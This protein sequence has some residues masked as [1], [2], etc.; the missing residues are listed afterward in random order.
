M[1]Y[2]LDTLVDITR[3]MDPDGK[4]AKIA[5]VLAE[6]NDMVL[7]MPWFPSNQ[8][9]TQVSTLQTGEPEGQF[10]ALNEAV[11]A[12]KPETEQISDGC[13]MLEAWSNIDC[14]AA[15]M[16]GNVS[17]YLENKDKAFIRGLGKTMAKTV[18][19]GDI[20]TN[21]KAFNGLAVRYNSTST[22]RGKGQI[23]KAGGSGSVNTSIY[24][25]KWGED[26]CHGLYPKDLQ[27]GLRYDFKGK[28]TVSPSAG[29]FM[30]VYQGKYEWFCGLHVVDYQAVVRIAN[31]D[32]T[33][34]ATAGTGSDT[35]ANLIRLMSLALDGLRDTNGNVCFYCNKTVMSIL[36]IQMM[37]RSNTW[38]T[39]IE[40][41]ADDPFN[42]VA[43]SP[44]KVSRCA[45]ST[46]FSTL[47][48]LFRSRLSP[49]KNKGG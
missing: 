22:G 23:L 37:N 7:D 30:D 29:T 45:A 6:T 3:Q 5:D 33:A 24:L 28:V 8:T 11:G 16:T 14:V 21:K 32:T 1:A 44:S 35:A 34:L 48:R 49:T 12:E 39:P 46:K 26:L 18:V 27:S 31:I 25:I 41:Q 17:K 2:A 42:A 4:P 36:R 15:E 10:R 13:A 43:H 20:K 40:W 19:N 47:R 38:F 9:M